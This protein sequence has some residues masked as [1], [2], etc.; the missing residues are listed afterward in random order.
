MHNYQ[1]SEIQEVS[2]YQE[3]EDTNQ[4]SSKLLGSYTNLKGLLEEEQS[5]D[6]HK[7]LSLLEN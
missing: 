5:N 2:S 7:T 4:K 6:L 1:P 3:E